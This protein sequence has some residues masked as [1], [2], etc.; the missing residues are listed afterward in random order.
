[1]GHRNSRIHIRTS[2]CSKLVMKDIRNMAWNLHEC[3]KLRGVADLPWRTLFEFSTWVTRSIFE[4][5]ELTG[6]EK[7]YAEE[8]KRF[9]QGMKDDLYLTYL[10]D[11]FLR[12]CRE[13]YK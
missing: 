3:S 2:H 5:D 9:P 8:T 13:L 10:S 11:A 7:K 4:A 12:Y 1:M 6:L